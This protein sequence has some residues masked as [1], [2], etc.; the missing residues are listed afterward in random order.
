MNTKVGSESSW[1]AAILF[2]HTRTSL[3]I[4]GLGPTHVLTASPPLL[5]IE[6]DPFLRNRL[7]RLSYTSFAKLLDTVSRSEVSEAPAMLPTASPTLRRMAVTMEVSRRIVSAT[8]GL[9]MRGFA[10]CYMESF[11]PWVKSHGGWVSDS[12]EASQI[13]SDKSWSCWEIRVLKCLLSHSN[14]CHKY[15]QAVAWGPVTQQYR[16]PLWPGFSPRGRR[17]W[18]TLGWSYHSDGAGCYITLYQPI[19]T[20]SEYPPS[21]PTNTKSK[22]NESV[23]ERSWFIVM[24]LELTSLLQLHWQLFLIFCPPYLLGKVSGTPLSTFHQ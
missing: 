21:L 22:H 5:Q 2:Y 6:S 17:C 12:S 18:V 4:C 11:A 13:S 3:W 24:V 8:G 23:S 20:C 7:S 15:V 1:C 16:Q 14:S 9:R 19:L 10:E